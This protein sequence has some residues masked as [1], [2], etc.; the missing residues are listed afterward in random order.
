M[1]K[2]YFTVSNIVRKQFYLLSERRY[3]NLSFEFGLTS[4]QHFPY[5]KKHYILDQYE[6]MGFLE[7][8]FKEQLISP[9]FLPF[10]TRL[11]QLQLLLRQFRNYLTL[12]MILA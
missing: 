6:L 7:S 8:L 10:F 5:R 3:S 2:M 11:T 9:P 12:Y 4:L 1:V